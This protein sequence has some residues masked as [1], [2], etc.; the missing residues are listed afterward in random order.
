MVIQN[1]SGADKNFVPQ[2]VDSAKGQAQSAAAAK[3]AQG[4]D[5]QSASAKSAETVTVSTVAQ[6]VG[7]VHGQI[8]SAPD[9]RREKVQ[10]IKDK[11]GKG[12]YKVSSDAIAGKVIEDIARQGNR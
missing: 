6:E 3:N 10:A 4:S 5:P 9:I 7:K 8:K 2:R 1:I 12:E 11:I